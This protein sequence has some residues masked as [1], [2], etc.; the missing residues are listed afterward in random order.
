[1][2]ED[3][4]S[5]LEVSK[6]ASEQDIKKAYRKLNLQ[7]HP[8]RNNSADAESKIRKINE[9]YETLGDQNKRQMYD[10]GFREGFQGGGPDINNIFNMFFNGGGIPGFGQGGFGSG[11]IHVFHNGMRHFAKPPPTQHIAVI[12]LEQ[13]FHGC[14]LDLKIN[15][16]VSC[17]HSRSEEFE[18]I[19]V[20]IHPGFDNES[21]ILQ[22]KGNIIENCKGDIHLVIKIENKTIFKRQ[23]MDLIYNKTLTLKEALCGVSFEITNLDEKIIK[24]SNLEDY[25]I[26][27]PNQ[28][29]IMPNMGMKK[30][31][32]GSG[33]LIIEFEIEFPKTLSFSQRESLDEIL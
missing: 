8:D 28:K 2:S 7:Y 29:I 9:A 6:D 31:G 5:I 3:F 15:R 4:Y 23:N 18:N 27:N 1:M 10:N 14:S 22:E 25:T 20:P 16:I 11:G 12:S 17:G 21:F 24:F 33:N 30:E 13:A 32:F 19:T 26:I